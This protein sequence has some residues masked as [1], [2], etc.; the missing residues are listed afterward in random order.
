M[1]SIGT[2]LLFL[3]LAAG[4]LAVAF[5]CTQAE[6]ET[7][8]IVEVTRE[9]PATVEVERQVE[10]TR[11]V[12]VTVQVERQVMV[13]REV[14]V[15]VEVERQVEVTR[16]VPVTV[17]VERQVEVTREV[18]VT[19]EVEKEVEATREVPVTVV[20][21][22]EVE[23]EIVREVPITV[24]VEVT[25]EIEVAVDA[26]YQETM[27]DVEDAFAAA[28]SDGDSFVWTTEICADGLDR[29]EHGVLMSM[30]YG[31]WLDG[32]DGDAELWEL[33]LAS[34]Y[35]TND[36]V[37]E[38]IAKVEAIQPEAS[39]VSYASTRDYALTDV[40]AHPCC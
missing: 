14:P 25:R 37:C 29:G 15:T 40:C 33:H 28:D 38:E 36:E 35:L 18:P 4:C 7:P 16:E 23:R 13:T 26:G 12:P 32:T 3:I 2:R 34:R 27:V 10:V 19:V 11:E 5:G 24:E 30:R 21:E 1:A 20:V 8:V 39:P 31:W 17:E 9:V 22:R 6:P